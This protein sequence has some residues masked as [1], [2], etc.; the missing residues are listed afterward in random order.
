MAETIRFEPNTPVRTKRSFWQ[1]LFHPHA[2]IVPVPGCDECREKL[3]RA[4]IPWP[5]PEAANTEPQCAVMHCQKQP[6][7][8]MANIPVQGFRMS[9]QLCQDHFSEF[10]KGLRHV[11]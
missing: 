3:E 1:R 6:V 7:A 2:H 11:Q 8:W 4:G 9:F 10:S 5:Y